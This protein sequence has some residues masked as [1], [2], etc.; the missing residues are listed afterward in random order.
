VEPVRWRTADLTRMAA[1]I[2][3]WLDEER[4]FIRQRID[5][6]VDAEDFKRLEAEM[7][8]L[9][10]EVRDPQN[11]L[12]L[13]D[14]TKAAKATFQARRAMVRALGRPTLKRMAIVN[15]TLVGRMMSRFI[16]VVSGL[17]KI[18]MF[19]DER[20]AIEWLLS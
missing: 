19:D 1:K 17:N 7:Q 15:A 8:R 13:F 11:V 18:R 6:Y 5:G 4:R 2:E 10:P 9:G 12:I 16:N 14:A 20:E 3:V